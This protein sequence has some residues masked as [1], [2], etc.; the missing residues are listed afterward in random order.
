MSDKKEEITS[1]NKPNE[2]TFIVD[3]RPEET[4]KLS[5][6]WFWYRGKKIKDIEQAYERFTAWLRFAEK[7]TSDE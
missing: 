5:E 6:G 3:N 4:L 1:D 2:I 7:E